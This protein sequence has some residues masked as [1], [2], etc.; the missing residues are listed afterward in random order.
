MASVQQ[1]HDS[2]EV[3]FCC[4]VIPAHVVALDEPFSIDSKQREIPRT[5][6]QCGDEVFLVFMIV[7]RNKCLQF[8]AFT[9]NVLP[10]L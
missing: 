8:D 9:H 6:L 7:P 4:Q 1:L 5:C 3:E 2:A 10:A